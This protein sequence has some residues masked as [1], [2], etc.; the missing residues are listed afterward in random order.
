M[1]Y[2]ELMRYDDSSIGVKLAYIKESEYDS[3][4]RSFQPTYITPIMEA[5]YVIGLEW[6]NKK[7]KKVVLQK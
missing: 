6:L 4:V 1:R 7:N 2:Y 3:C 5:E